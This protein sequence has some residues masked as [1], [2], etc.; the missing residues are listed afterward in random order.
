[1]IYLLVNP[2]GGKLWR[3][4]YRHEGKRNTCR[5]APTPA[6]PCPMA[7]HGL[8][9]TLLHEQG[10]PSDLIECQLAHAERNE[11]KAACNHAL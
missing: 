1:M 5:S 2:N 9:S 7:A 10:W 11:I 3:M 6:F 4:N 8:A